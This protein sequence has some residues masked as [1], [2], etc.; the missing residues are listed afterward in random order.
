[1]SYMN[2]NNKP[3]IPS[4]RKNLLVSSVGALLLGLISLG[5]PLTASATSQRTLSLRSAA[6]TYVLA[7]NAVDAQGNVFAVSPALNQVL[8]LPAATGTLFGQ[9]VVR[10]HM[11]QLVAMKGLD[12]AAGIAVDGHGD[13]FVSNAGYADSVTVLAKTT[14]TIFGQA[15]VANRSATLTATHGIISPEGLTFGHNG[16][17]YVVSAALNLVAVVPAVSGTYFGD[18]AHANQ[19]TFLTATTTLDSPYGVAVDPAGNLFVTATGGVHA[20]CVATGQIYGQTFTTNQLAVLTAISVPISDTALGIAFD[21]ASDLYVS[22]GNGTFVIPGPATTSLF[23]ATV[24]PG[25]AS[26]VANGESNFVFGLSTNPAG[27]LFLDLVHINQSYISSNLSIIP[28]ASGMFDGIPLVEGRLH[29]FAN[30]TVFGP[31][32]GFDGP[33]LGGVVADSQGNAFFTSPNSGQVL[34]LPKVTGSLFGQHVRA[35]TVVAVRALRTLTNPNAI[36]ID[37]RDDLFVG[38]VSSG[39]ITVLTQKPQTVFGQPVQPNTATSLR[40]VSTSSGVTGM[41]FDARGDLVYTISQE[42]GAYVIA[43]VTHDFFGQRLIQRRDV[44]ISALTST[45]IGTGSPQF[46]GSGT[47]YLL[48]TRLTGNNDVTVL[49]PSLTRIFGQSIPK[50]TP[51]SLNVSANLFPDTFIPLDISLD[52]NGDLFLAGSGIGQGGTSGSIFVI[53]VHSGALLGKHVT[54]NHASLISGGLQASGFVASYWR[55]GA[56]WALNPNGFWSI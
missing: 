38:Q 40:T 46:D 25:V 45:N 5:A 19:T 31:Y 22:L 51:T 42:G 4:M 54:A 26:Y 1:M 3:R 14:R 30:R 15:F 33:P 2:D 8:V 27:D 13:L 20:L 53:P 56:L 43:N 47:L 29:Q 48:T 32:R 50:N 41:T 36:A 21:S 18:F 55:L 28:H 23:G 11:T 52:S 10:G 49:A 24:T 16:E 35:G 17:L 39:A 37:K 9:R 12:T 34:V 6:A 7:G 44:A